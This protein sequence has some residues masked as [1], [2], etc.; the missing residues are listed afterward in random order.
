[1]KFRGRSVATRLVAATAAFA[2]FAS[3]GLR[4]ARGAPADIFSSAAPAFGAG[5][6]KA[7]ELHAGDATVSIETGA[8]TFAYPI[9]APPGR[10]GVVP[11]LSLSYSSQAPIYG[12]IAAG[13]ELAVPWMREE[14][15]TSR[16]RATSDGPIYT[17]GLT[18]GQPLIPFYAPTLE[19]RAVADSSFVRYFK[20]ADSGTGPYWRALAPEGQR[21]EFGGPTASTC[22]NLSAKNAPLTQVSDPF[23]NTITYTWE[24]AGPFAPR[25]T[26][27]RLASVSYGANANASVGDFATIEFVYP[28]VFTDFC[29]DNG[30]VSVGAAFDYRGG[31][32][33]M[34]GASQLDAIVVTAYPPGTGPSS[35]EHKRTISLTYDPATK[36]C[37]SQAGGHDYA[38]FRQLLKISEHI[39]SANG[40][41]PAVDPPAVSFSYGAP[42]LSYPAEGTFSL[43]W[44]QAGEAPTQFKNLAWGYTFTDGRWPTL[45]ATFIDMDGDGLPDRVRNLRNPLQGGLASCT[46]TWQKNLGRDGTGV[47]TFEPT[48]HTIAMPRLKWGAST[49]QPYASYA[50]AFA[51]DTHPQD[52]ALNYQQTYYFNSRSG[53]SQ[54][55]GDGI[56]SGVC[57]NANAVCSNGNDCVDGSSGS[58][59]TILAYR[60]VDFDGDG[61]TDLV[62]G[63]AGGGLNV[64]NL[65]RGNIPC[66]EAANCVGSSPPDNHAPDEGSAGGLLASWPPC[67]AQP[68]PGLDAKA[69]YSMCGGMYPWFV[70]KNLGAGVLKTTP[71]VFYQPVPLEAQDTDSGITGL[72]VSQHSGT[73]DLDGDGYADAV[74]G[75]VDASAT[76][77]R[78]FA[79][80]G[81][82]AMTGSGANAF[83]FPTRTGALLQGTTVAGSGS[84]RTIVS[85]AG[86]VDLNGDGLP[87]HWTGAVDA[88]SLNVAWND[89]AQFRTTSAAGHPGEGFLSVRPAARAGTSQDVHGVPYLRYDLDRLVDLDADGRPDVYQFE[90]GKRFYN[91]GGVFDP[92]AD[93]L[94]GEAVGVENLVLSSTAINYPSYLG[95]QSLTAASW[96]VRSDFV[97]LDGDGIP[98]D[99]DFG[100]DG[101]QTSV[102]PKASM[103]SVGGHPPRLMT[104]IDNG[105]GATTSVVY[106]SIH[107]TTLVT[108]TSGTYAASP[109][110]QWI[111]KSVTTADQIST[112]S[113]TTTYAYKN[114]ISGR[115]ALNSY[116][117]RGFEEVTATAP[118]LATTTSRFRFDTIVPLAT[119]TVVAPAP[120]E[121]TTGAIRSKTHTDWAPFDLCAQGF[122]T[123]ITAYPH[124]ISYFPVSSHH[125][126]C[127]NGQ[128]EATCTASGTQTTTTMDVEMQQPT[129]ASSGSHFPAPL[130]FVNAGTILSAGDGTNPSSYRATS[131]TYELDGNQ[132]TYRLRGITTTHTAVEGGS[133][134]VFG[135]SRTKWDDSNRVPEETQT[136]FSNPESD[137]C[138]VSSASCAVDK[139]IYDLTTGN[140]IEHRKPVQNS[141]GVAGELFS[142][143]SRKL[144]VAT[145]LKEAAG[146]PLTCDPSEPDCRRMRFDYEYDYGTGA[147]LKTIGPNAR[148]CTTNCPNDPSHPPKQETVTDIDAMGR[149]IRQW[150]T[151]ASDGAPNYLL[152]QVASFTYSEGSATAPASVLREQRRDTSSGNLAMG[153]PADPAPIRELSEID[154]LGRPFRSTV[155]APDQPA[156]AVTTTHYRSDGTVSSVDVPDPTQNNASVV[157]YTYAFDS[158]GRATRIRR[159]DTT[160][161]A[162]QSGANLVYDG[163]TTTA[164]EVVKAGDGVPAQTVTK[165]DAFGRVV[166]VHE[167]TG[168][169]SAI[170][171]YTYDASDA[172]VAIQDP[173]DRVTGTVTTT[174]THDLA[175][176]RLS[177]THDGQTWNYGYDK[178]G[179]MVT[180]MFPGWSDVFDQSL[181]TTSV[182]YDALDRPASK[183]IA[184]RHLSAADLALFGDDSEVYTWDYGNYHK[185]Y[186]RYWVARPPGSTTGS[187]VS[188][189]LGDVDGHEDSYRQTLNIAGYSN[190][191]NIVEGNLYITGQLRQRKFFD[192]V[193][194]SNSTYEQLTYDK[195]GLPLSVS[196]YRGELGTLTT[197]ATN[198][199]N[200]AGLVTNQ[201][202]VQS[203]SAMTS[204]DDNWSYDKLGRVTS[205]AIQHAPGTVLDARQD[206]A[207]FGNDDPKSM[208]VYLGASNHKK[209]NY[210]YDARHQI[211][212]VTESQLPNAFTGHYRYSPGGKFATVSEA[213]AALPGKELVD[214]DVTYAFAAAA[215]DQVTSLTTSSGTFASY[216]YDETGN[217]LTRCYGGYTGSNCNG[218]L[219]TYLY[220]GK[221]QL[222]RATRTSSA[223]I[224]QGS[225]EYWYDGAGARIAIVKRDGSGNKTELVWFNHGR[226]AHLDASGAVTHVYSYI[227]GVARVDRTSNT[228]SD[229]EYTF[230]GL[231]DSM[232]AAVDSDG[233]TNAAFD[234]APFGGVIETMDRA[235]SSGANTAEHRMRFNNKYSDE[236]SNLSYYGARYYDSTSVQWTQADPLYR[237]VP[238]LAKGSQLRGNL[239]TFS[240]NNSLRY[241]DPDGQDAKSGGY[242]ADYRSEFESS[243]SAA[244]ARAYESSDAWMAVPV[245]SFD[246]PAPAW[247]VGGGDPKPFDPCN[248]AG[249][250]CGFWVGGPF[251]D[252]PEI[253]SV[254]D[255]VARVVLDRDSSTTSQ[256][257]PPLPECADPEGCGLW[258]GLNRKRVAGSVAD[259]VV[260]GFSPS[261]SSSPFSGGASGLPRGGGGGWGG[262]PTTPTTKT[263]VFAAD[264]AAADEIIANQTLSGPGARA[265]AL[266]QAGGLLA[267]EEN[268]LAGGASR[269]GAMGYPRV[270]SAA[271]SAGKEAPLTIV[272]MRV[273]ARALAAMRDGGSVITSHGATVFSAEAVCRCSLPV[274]SFEHL[275]D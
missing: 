28:S 109:H 207:Y 79:N 85:T 91:Q 65:Q 175:G 211:Y 83:V 174:M 156:N 86:V 201:H 51:D 259:G 122:G 47:W 216:T 1:M 253:G 41:I 223:R 2:V 151:Y 140:L 74:A 208:D 269:A 186:L 233:M 265:G 67:P 244:A 148:T 206:L 176:R 111:V 177:I 50:I 116:V 56:A 10:N 241:S 107:D 55:C 126:T 60:W 247:F 159:P 191:T 92:M 121:D 131:T 64:Y 8:F 181:F 14:T 195:R 261:S 46:T 249:T 58:P 102:S 215:P 166:E 162:D 24:P 100:I 221:N 53:V 172:V 171:T 82:G 133:S 230:H 108:R 232:L 257:G 196:V 252:P 78:A 62:A 77:W 18:S 256:R 135:K 213:S 143:D 272:R 16:L 168:G 225:E 155:F 193:G 222:R 59:P 245:L 68:T 149:P 129:Y 229:L 103:A 123:C 142:Y 118:S 115:D 179:N 137:D 89:G 239:Y 48:P 66:S 22:T 267:F 146:Y 274:A 219:T 35:F 128:T 99:Y 134:T 125:W 72:P 38:A 9:I 98:E 270:T 157:S 105:R 54:A 145:D 27:C 264:I 263:F 104:Q 158:L 190:L 199:R 268:R 189:M 240:M 224:V 218:Y 251:F 183:T 144:F 20:V 214:R 180:E 113:A 95:N 42:A 141:A 110:A 87:D 139:R 204:L 130:M 26:E 93:V 235:G 132:T 114:P 12:G 76:S 250:M 202:S 185:G 192:Q 124:L 43:P 236:I 266:N 161:S 94:G 40:N 90:A 262:G 15:A 237:F 200:V 63:I 69:P 136:W 217:Q 119:D 198:T 248:D 209:F 70:Y 11:H 255:I 31:F 80:D 138:Q 112:T 33:R 238:D 13:W 120:G 173:D 243:Q 57:S 154:G 71:D 4:P 96:Q 163:L 258:L 49:H 271:I 273:N 6:P 37:P 182:V 3:V 178:N 7:A 153:G 127:Q 73:F 97:D 242:L 75:S 188:E 167:S 23:G 84:T 260:E 19:Y 61:L 165:A 231:G 117:F 88:T 228:S 203:G 205:Q 106:G 160:T 184:P 152:Y 187:V 52:C 227:G 101:D 17:S 234:Y 36:Q 169:A 29:G 150:V 210:V 32:P 220:D 25:N 164:T 194:G 246:R 34:S 5:P 45:E 21:Y 44:T 275:R 212:D 170:T 147:T 226:E 81:S 39:E 254:T 30:G 197:I